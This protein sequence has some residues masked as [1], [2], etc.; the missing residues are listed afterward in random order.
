MGLH[1]FFG[2]P[3]TKGKR[4]EEVGQMWEENIPAWRSASWTPTI[5]ID[6]DSELA[7]KLSVEHKETG[8]QSDE[9]VH[10]VETHSA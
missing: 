1:V 9:K 6:P 4:L 3:E 2:F 5:P 8:S 7:R 10:D